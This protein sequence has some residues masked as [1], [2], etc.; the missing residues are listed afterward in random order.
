M[1]RAAFAPPVPG[2]LPEAGVRGGLASGPRVEVMSQAGV[3]VGVFSVECLR[4]FRFSK[5]NDTSYTWGRLPALMSNS[6]GDKS[7]PALPPGGW[8]HRIRAPGYVP[9]WSELEQIRGYWSN[10]RVIS[11]DLK[12]GGCIAGTIVDESGE[13]IVG[14]SVLTLDPTYSDSGFGMTHFLSCQ[15]NSEAR[16]RT[17][18]I[19]GFF[20]PCLTPGAYQLRL[21]HPDFRRE[22]I[23][24]SWSRNSRQSMRLDS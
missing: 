7:I 4:W 14:A 18:A 13:P 17:D 11:V 9:S 23:R 1:P 16:G 24:D 15:R 12:Q 20:L 22:F 6:R 21:S 10:P 19:G 3:P 5:S 8:V 2:P